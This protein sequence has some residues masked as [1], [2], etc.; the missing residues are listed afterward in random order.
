MLFRYIFM[1]EY[2]ALLA[3]YLVL[4]F[5]SKAG[6]HLYQKQKNKPITLQ[7]EKRPN[8]YPGAKK[9][10]FLNFNTFFADLIKFP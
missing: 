7:K 8:T 1:N 5:V 4:L 10:Y 6:F 2:I 9:D 3:V